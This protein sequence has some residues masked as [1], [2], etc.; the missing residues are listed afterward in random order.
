MGETPTGLP[1]P[2]HPSDDGHVNVPNTYA[3]DL[4]FSAP[5][6]RVEPVLPEPKDNLEPV[7][8]PPPSPPPPPEEPAF[9]IR[10]RDGLLAMGTAGMAA[11]GVL[12]LGL[13]GLVL[14]IAAYQVWQSD[15][16][17]VEGSVTATA[18]EEA[19]APSESV[20]VPVSPPGELD[21]AAE[22]DPADEAAEP[23]TATPAVRASPTPGPS[24]TDNSVWGPLDPAAEPA[25]PLPAEVPEKKKKR[26][27]R[28]KD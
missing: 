7:E 16:P 28:R 3:L 17:P 5:A 21:D 4:D 9:P 27:K 20:E 1:V 18:V 22:P 24:P 26:K 23:V 8:P 15:D 11:A 14:A 12:A 2:R 19:P 13:S 25:A 6:P 10:A